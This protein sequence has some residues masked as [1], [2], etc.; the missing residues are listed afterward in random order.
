MAPSEAAKTG[1]IKGSA[2]E[3]R[4]SHLCDDEPYRPISVRSSTVLTCINLV[5]FWQP[6]ERKFERGPLAK[7]SV[8]DG[9]A[10]ARQVAASSRTHH[11]RVFGRRIPVSRY[12]RA[13]ATSGPV[14][15]FLFSFHAVDFAEYRAR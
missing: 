7:F 6:R 2:K 1:A 3:P 4:L 5:Q 9:P 13:N 12:Y 15:D 8:P 11:H 10:G 14:R